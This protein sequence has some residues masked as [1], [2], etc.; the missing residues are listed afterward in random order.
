MATRHPVDGQV[1]R[2]EVL[3]GS[4]ALLAGGTLGGSLAAMAAGSEPVVPAEPPPLPWKWVKLDPLEAGQRAYT[5]YKEKGGCGTGAYLAL[6]SLL[7]EQAGY[8]WTTMPDM[9][10][11]HAASG[12]GG[13]GTLCGALAG[14]STIINMVTYGEERDH[15]LQNSQVVDRL[16]WWYAE[17]HFPT[18]RFDDIS[19]LPGQ[20]RAKAMSPLCHTSV[21]RWVMVAGEG[22]KTDAKIERCSKVVGEVTYT[23]VEALNRFFAGEWTPAAWEPSEDIAHC[24]KCHGPA[25]R[26]YEARKWNQQGHMECLMCHDDHTVR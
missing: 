11:A 5:L 18:D 21:S 13:H 24:V 14:A 23:V 25:G 19:P 7:K 9:L 22:I 20:V 12:F 10:M 16:F 17:Q 2:R 26:T 3:A 8:P 1:S 15:I 4:V 6:L